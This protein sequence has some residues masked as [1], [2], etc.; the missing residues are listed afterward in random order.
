MS[1]EEND[2]AFKL[3]EDLRVYFNAYFSQKNHEG[4]REEEANKALDGVDLD[5]EVVADFLED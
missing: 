4:N 1:Q 2:A 5:R 3:D